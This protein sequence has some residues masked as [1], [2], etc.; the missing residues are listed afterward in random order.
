MELIGLIIVA[1]MLLLF[2]GFL[3]SWINER[4]LCTIILGIGWAAALVSIGYMGWKH[5]QIEKFQIINA[6]EIKKSGEEAWE[7]TIKSNKGNIEKVWIKKKDLDTYDRDS[8]FVEA[9]EFYKE[10]N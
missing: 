6:V 7:F 4:K 1:L 10:N 8:M 3:L 9:T 5:D 2:V